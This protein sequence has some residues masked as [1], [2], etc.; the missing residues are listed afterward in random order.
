M[1]HIS[2]GADERYVLDH[3]RPGDIVTHCFHGRRNG[4]IADTA[5]GFIP[6]LRLARERGV[7]FDIG[8]GCGSFSWETARRAFEH[9][10]WPDT[11]ST[12]LHRY[13][14]DAPWSLTLPQVMSKFMCLGMSLAEVIAKTTSAP[15]A[16][17][18]PRER[19]RI[20]P[21]GIGCGSSAISHSRRTVHV[22]RL[23]W[24]TAPGRSTDR[25]HTRDP[26]RNAIPAGRLSSN[27][28]PNIPVRPDHI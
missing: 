23:T 25:T 6:Q 7:I 26:Q 17:A 20:A 2:A 4:M 21:P 16:R 8:H 18:A 24:D 14:V 5:E 3:L 1:T 13:S 15:A 10:F 28:P 11:I 27:A 9:H 12:D 19:L 22:R